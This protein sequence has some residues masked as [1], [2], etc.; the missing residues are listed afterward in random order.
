MTRSAAHLLAR[1]L[2]EKLAELDLDPDGVLAEAGLSARFPELRK[3]R[4]PPLSRS[5]LAAL[6]HACMRAFEVDAS[7]RAGRPT[8]GEE[9]MDL[10]CYCII[11]CTTLQEAIERAARFL[12]AIYR[13][14]GRPHVHMHL[15]ETG[16]TAE[17]YLR[18]GEA[19]NVVSGLLSDLAAAALFL[20]LFGWLIGEEIEVLEA[21]V[22]HE[23]LLSERAIA[24][25]FPHPLVFGRKDL[26]HD[27]E[28][29]LSFASRYLQRPVVRSTT[30][31]EDLLRLSLF[32]RMTALTPGLLLSDTVRTI[33]NRSLARGVS[34]PSTGRVA[35]LCNMSS[36]TLRRHLAQ[37]GA[38]IRKIRDECLQ[39]S[40]FQLLRHSG[41]PLSEIASRLGFSDVP[42]FH[43][44]FRRWAHTSPSAYRRSA[45]PLSR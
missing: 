25:I 14:G 26:W 3:G 9:E 41:T 35:V 18:S 37:Q 7:R 5:E 1:E 29:R 13:A 40:A 19:R 36:A 38:S 16:S 6:Y 10:L 11:T 23:Q 44:A 31:L 42:S 22:C 12:T 21:S 45:G 8:M 33:F 34:L 28:I 2:L 15:C 39:R 4:M 20:K 32:D 43:R 24:E 27:S 30:D 17:L